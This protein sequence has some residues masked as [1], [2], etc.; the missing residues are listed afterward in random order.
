MNHNRIT[1]NLEYR[2]Q[3]GSLLLLNCPTFMQFGIDY[4]SWTVGD[5]F[6]G[7]KLIPDGPHFIHYSLKEEEYSFKQG[8]FIHVSQKNKIHIRKWDNEIKDFVSLKSE[9]DEKNFSI[10]INNLEFDAYL[11]NYPQDQIDNWKDLTGFID[12]KILER[13]EPINRRYITS[14]KEYEEGS[15]KEGQN[16]SIK[17]N[18]Y[19]TSIPKKKFYLNQVDPFVLT[20]SNLD[21]SIILE[22]LIIKEYSNDPCILLGE[23]QYSFITFYL[24]EIYESF[25]QWKN[26]FI[27]TCSCKELIGKRE[28]FFCDFI[29]IVYH[30]LRQLPKDFFIDEISSNNFIGRMFEIFFDNCMD[31]SEAITKRIKLLQKFLKEFFGFEIKDENEKIIDNYL[32]KKQFYNN[33]QEDYDDEM[34]AIVDE[35]EVNQILHNCETNE[36]DE[37][38][39]S[40]HTNDVDIV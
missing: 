20:Q 35:N 13:L 5:K 33:R 22:E 38:T 36:N 11:G 4:S 9:E 3:S 10:G 19:Y 37:T 26:I 17:G 21:K 14:S 7:I 30:Q 39:L 34:P 2:L 15:A 24:G 32:I 23:F 28:K 40:I 12:D 1:Y 29:E 16:N 18:I 27:L 6:K 31:H 8:F 25:E